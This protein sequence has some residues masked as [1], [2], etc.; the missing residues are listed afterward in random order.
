MTD[1]DEA[2]RKL[3]TNIANR[4]NNKNILWSSYDYDMIYPHEA[5]DAGELTPEEIRQC[6][7]NAVPHF[8]YA[9]TASI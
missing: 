9:L 8:E 6:I 2:G 7:I 4:L 1:N 3:G 5:K